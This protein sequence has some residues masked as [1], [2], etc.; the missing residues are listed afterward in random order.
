MT[1][2]DSINNILISSSRFFFSE[3][4]ALETV[5]F[6]VIQLILHSASLE[7]FPF[8]FIFPFV[9]DSKK[10]LGLSSLMI[11]FKV[12]GYVTLNISEKK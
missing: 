10:P 3:T 6:T 4:I 11:M 5:H 9:N 1:V 12:H 2:R 7:Y 8:I